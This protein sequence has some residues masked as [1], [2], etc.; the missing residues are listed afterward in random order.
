MV[1]QKVGQLSLH[2]HLI[3]T[4]S[5]GNL[6]LSFPNVVNDKSIRQVLYLYAKENESSS[7]HIPPKPGCLVIGN[8]GRNFSESKEN[9]LH[10]T[11]ASH[12][13]VASSLTKKWHKDQGETRYD[14][15]NLN[16]TGNGT[17]GRKACMVEGS[18][19]SPS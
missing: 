2:M 11:L 1:Y 5:G 4:S 12:I 3:S 10:G 14:S 6:I 18:P 19:I 15:L 7:H 8:I 9:T 13:T 16:H 17:P